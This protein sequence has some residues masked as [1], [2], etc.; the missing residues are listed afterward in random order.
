MTHLLFAGH[1]YYPAGGIDDLVARGTV[2][3]LKRYFEEHAQEIADRTNRY[4][5]NW[6]QIVDA[7]TMEC[8]LRGEIGRG[9]RSGEDL[10]VA[11]WQ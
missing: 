1:A 9:S 3:E 5:D 7:S 8:V 6:G 10:G 4:V 11:V 2:D